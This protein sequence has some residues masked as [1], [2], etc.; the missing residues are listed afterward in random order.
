MPSYLDFDSTKGFRDKMLQR[1]LDP[2][3]TKSPSPKTFKKD[4]Y[5]V[6]NL[7]DSQN[8][9]LP[10]VDSNRKSDLSIPKSSNVFKPD[11][12]FIKDTID[13]LPRRA[14]LSLYPYFT[15]TN[16]NL[17]GIMGNSNYDTESELF[18]F[19]AHNIK[20]NPQGPVRARIQ[21]NLY[22]ETTA[23]VRILEAVKGNTTTLVNIIRG[24]EQLIEGNNRITVNNSLLGQGVDFLQTVAGLQLPFSEI[25]GDYLSNPRAP[26][27]TRPTE[28]VSAATRV[29]QDLTGTLGSI[30]GI[31]RR[32]LPS[33]KPS[34]LLI[35]Y[36]GSSSKNRLFD[37]L[38]YSKYAPNYTTGAR[39]QQSSRLF[40]IPG[41]FA[42]GVR[43]LLGTEAPSGIAYIGDD[44]SNNLKQATTDLF[45]GRPVRSSY[46]LSLMFDPIASVLFHRDKNISE[47]GTISGNLTWLS[48]NKTQKSVNT[49]SIADSISTN[50]TFRPD[51][52]LETTQ[53]IL[54]SKPQNGGDAL[55]HI[56]H[57]LDQT[58]KYFKDG[59]TLISRGSGVRYMDNS[60]KDIGVEYARVWTKDRPYSTRAS[61]APYYK[62]T[63]T[64]PYY[65]GTTKPYR[66]TTVRKFD[67]S[68]LND[69]WNLN[70]AP[71]SDGNKGFDGSTNIVPKTNDNF[72]AKKYMLSIENLAWKSST[73]PGYTVSDL[74]YSERGPNGGRV[75]WFPP[76][77]LKVSEQNTA[78][79][80]KNVFLG[81]PE[82]I[83]TYQ[84]TERSGQ[85]SFKIVVD[86]P[87]ILNLLVREHFKNMSE[88]QVDQYVNAFFAGAKDIDFYS[89]IRTYTNLDSNDIEMIQSYLNNRGDENV[90]NNKINSI[91]GPV[92]D[93]PEGDTT[94][95]GNSATVS[96][97]GTLYYSKGFP[98]QQSGQDSKG[99]VS[100]NTATSDI[101]TVLSISGETISNLDNGLTSII[102]N[103]TPNDILDRKTIFNNTSVDITA[104]ENIKLSLTNILTGLTET[105]NNFLTAVENLQSD[106]S[107]N[108]IQKDVVINIGSSSSS[109]DS[110][111]YNHKL[112]LRRTSA[113][114]NDILDIINFNDNGIANKWANINADEPGEN[115]ITNELI[116]YTFKELGYEGSGT[117]YIKSTNYGEKYPIQGRDCSQYKLNNSNLEKF[118]PVPYGCRQSTIL[119]DYKKN[120]TTPVS[121]NNPQD[122]LVNLNLTGTRPPIDIMKRII[123]KTLSEQYYFKQLEENSPLVFSSLKEKL[124]YFHPAFHSM[125]PEG[126]NSRL[127]FLQQCLRPGNTLPVKG[128][129]DDS[130]LNARNTTFG[131]PPICVMRVGDFYHS[132][133][134]IRDLNITFDDATWDLN[135]E[136]IGVQPMIANVSLQ[137][138]FIGGQGLEKPVERLQNALSSNFYANTEMYD[139]RSETTNTTMGGQK[140]EDFT[141][142][143]IKSLNDRRKKAIDV[144][145]KVGLNYTEGQ[146][147]GELSGG[148]ALNYTTLINNLFKST[149]EYFDSYEKMYNNIV[150]EYGSSLSDF[151]INHTYRRSNKYTVKTGSA[152]LDIELF[153]LYDTYVNLDSLVD[154]TKGKFI[155]YVNE[156]EVYKHFG[157]ENVINPNEIET[158][159]GILYNY[160][161]EV[162]DDKFDSMTNNKAITDFEKIRNGII[163]NLDKLNYI[164]ENDLDVKFQDGKAFSASLTSF[165]GVTFYNEYKSCVDYFVDNTSKMYENLDSS[166]VNYFPN[167]INLTDESFQKIIS[168][169]FYDK[170]DEIVGRLTFEG[171][172]SAESVKSIEKGLN[173]FFEKPK[174][175]NFKF[176]KKPKRKNNTN[177]VYPI[178]VVSETTVSDD[179]KKLFANT[180]NITAIGSKLNYYKI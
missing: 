85:L 31:Q 35:D 107:K 54:D 49:T 37:L 76:Y 105:K 93:N 82:P 139:E 36:M 173:K 108:L 64:R 116:A 171:D 8:L 125:T 45:S 149:T 96:F 43:S 25:P 161:L 129:S 168:N 179:I 114:I 86:H 133:V 29:W 170:K 141:R 88:E 135:P 176:S 175:V 58:S 104:K 22:N 47:Q 100:N 32:P 174:S 9:N 153:G 91:S 124:K 15:Q 28:N 113:V 134:V 77:D 44:R 111:S 23:K 19:A 13:S 87:S 18:K 46:Y 16:E 24:K 67:S 48:K 177:V 17:I 165:T 5:P 98:E 53:Q 11:Q 142:E 89:L 30:V 59:D 65:S 55:A 121:G 83:F 156:N 61:T 159:N 6:Q 95:N 90:I 62:E 97:R 92:I 143:F 101:D 166:L 2:V 38:S 164:T 56:G 167:N 118:A 106:L 154:E 123:M 145:D 131:P 14:N 94:K 66:R 99:W 169:L 136:G 103:S 146:Y 117:L 68:V 109:S 128:I 130:D 138:N 69:T 140:T 157:L 126:L 132:K 39:S 3:Y 75:M 84:N 52:I 102:T 147:I 144:K 122:Q 26:I 60:G 70:I 51:S 63:E 160:Y 12:Y 34:D 40:Q 178:N 81:R 74:P 127:T 42:Q 1:T 151:M 71:M 115:G 148:T 21:Q 158:V 57:I 110:A 10:D 152:P 137:L 150:L 78:N 172:L 4:T 119:I 27:N 73:Q 155:D 20:D 41:L 180:Y 7:G 162:I 79:W 50:F 80:D 120:D 72:Y 163:S 33:R 112:S